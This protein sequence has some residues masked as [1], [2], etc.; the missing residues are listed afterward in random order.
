MVKVVA[1]C[2]EGSGKDVCGEEVVRGGSS[3]VICGVEEVVEEVVIN[4]EHSFSQAP[5]TTYYTI[6][7][8]F[9]THH[10][11]LQILIKRSYP[12]VLWS[13]KETMVMRM[14][15]KKKWKTLLHS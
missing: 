9:T 15:M 14:R 3:M 13:Q 6:P 8:T 12:L 1:V 4:T 10:L 2:G 11:P 5:S 7:S